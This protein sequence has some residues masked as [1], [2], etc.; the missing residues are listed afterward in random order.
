MDILVADLHKAGAGFCQ[1]FTTKKQA[2]T[3]VC[4]I[5]MDAELPSIA[6]CFDHLRFLGEVLVF[7]VLYLAPVYERLEVRAVLDAVGWV[8]VDHLHLPSQP[9]FL[10][11]R[12]HHQERVARDHPVR[13]TVLMLVEVDSLPEW[14]VLLRGLKEGGLLYLD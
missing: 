6:K 9:L 1:E 14:R 13:P 4:E 12:V 8:D 10:N 11:Q 5:G 3:Q 7:P 2:S